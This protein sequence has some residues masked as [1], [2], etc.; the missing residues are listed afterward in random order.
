MIEALDRITRI[1]PTVVAEFTL[2]S[3]VV[4]AVI[5]AN[6]DDSTTLL[7]PER[8]AMPIYWASQRDCDQNI[9]KIVLPIGTFNYTTEE[10]TKNGTLTDSQKRKLVEQH[11]G[12]VQ[13]G[14]FMILDEVQKGGTI[15]ELT[16][17]VR[18][19]HGG[20]VVVIAAQ[21]TALGHLKANKN[22]YYTRMASNHLSR[23][24]TTVV[25]L[26]LIAC[27]R[28]S[29]LDRLTYSGNTRIATDEKPDIKIVPNIGAETIFRA[30]G[31]LF[32]DVDYAN[33][34]SFEAGLLD[35]PMS[36]VRHE[37][38]VSIIKSIAKHV[39]ERRAH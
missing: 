22:P 32:S 11:I 36:T 7:L 25:P 6:I 12:S 9:D 17:Y 27:D 4:R 15:S 26:P 14:R 21:D 13:T 23:V 24:S 20:E 37:K 39:H 19:I 10:G 16:G 38:W 30:L 28:P 33:S 8:G 35:T 34:N 18:N 29:L 31:T 1:H 3:G 5:D 2:G